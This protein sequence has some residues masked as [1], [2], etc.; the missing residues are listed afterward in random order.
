MPLLLRGKLLPDPGDP[1]AVHVPLVHRIRRRVARHGIR[2]ELHR[3][4]V[5]LQGVEELLGLVHRHALV[6]RG[7]EDERRRADAVR[8]GDG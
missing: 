1:A 5:V 6:T 8:E 7:D 3:R 4:T 2:D